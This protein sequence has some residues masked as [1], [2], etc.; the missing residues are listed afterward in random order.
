MCCGGCVFVQKVSRKPECGERAKGQAALCEAVA[1]TARKKGFSRRH[2]AENNYVQ[3][4]RRGVS[5]GKSAADFDGF[6]VFLIGLGRKGK[7]LPFAHKGTVRVKQLLPEPD[8]AFADFSFVSSRVRAF[9]AEI[10]GKKSLRVYSK[11][12]FKR[13]FLPAQS[14]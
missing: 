9:G 13:A 3:D 7:L 12:F 2:R 8:C 14:F 1:D 4:L 10:S 6:V 5:V 11:L